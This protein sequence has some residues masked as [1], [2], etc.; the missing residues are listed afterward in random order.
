MDNQEQVQPG[1]S[2]DNHG[3]GA[4]TSQENKRGKQGSSTRLILAALATVIIIGAALEV[5]GTTSF[6]GGM[7]AAAYV[8]GEKISQKDVDARFEQILKSPQGQGV[9]QSNEEFVSGLRSQLLEN[10]INTRLLIQAAKEADIVVTADMI[11]SEYKTLSTQYGGEE[12][13]LAAA[14]GEGFSESGL[15]A[16]I[17]EQLMI[18]QYLDTRIDRDGFSATDEEIRTFYNENVRDVEGAPALSEI[19]AQ[20]EAELIS[21][22]QQLEI[23][24]VITELRS[25][26]EITIVD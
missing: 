14:S 3:G 24:N 1:A 7:K 12:Q 15:R 6:F 19:R 8:N 16:D 25:A 13:L 22:K 10:M 4:G 11:D 23:G 20:I 5:T 9:D 2:G 18:R 21:R 26:A 17:E